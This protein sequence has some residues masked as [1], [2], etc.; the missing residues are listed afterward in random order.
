M[1]ILLN[2]LTLML[3]VFLSYETHLTCAQCFH[4]QFGR[5]EV[6]ACV[7]SMISSA[8][9]S[10]KVTFFLHF[11]VLFIFHI[12]N[13]Y[14]YSVTVGNFMHTVNRIFSS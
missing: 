12:L 9:N 14:D 6:H 3:L 1:Y 4:F 5:S 2:K 10:G 7:S 11:T 8:E 13:C